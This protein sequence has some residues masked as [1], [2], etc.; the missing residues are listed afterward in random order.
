MNNTLRVC[1]AGSRAYLFVK[2]NYAIF[3]ILF[4][5]DIEY[6]MA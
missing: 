2:K 3:M 5:F 4:E 1:A 6:F